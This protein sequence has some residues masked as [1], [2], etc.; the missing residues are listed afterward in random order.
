[1][2]RYS[3]TV[4]P[5]LMYEIAAPYVRLKFQDET[6]EFRYATRKEFSMW[7]SLKPE[8]RQE[9]ENLVKALELMVDPGNLK[10][11][12][13]MTK[14]QDILGIS[15]GEIAAKKQRGELVYIPGDGRTKWISVN[16]SKPEDGTLVL[17]TVLTTDCKLVVRTGFYDSHTRTWR[18]GKAANVIAWMPAPD[19]YEGE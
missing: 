11:I 8:I 3:S 7:K 9:L 19:P 15:Y 14:L 6:V 2:I 4:M 16:D 10:P 1:M 12:D 17:V 18:A 5:Y 13:V